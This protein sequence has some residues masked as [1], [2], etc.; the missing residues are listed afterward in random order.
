ME[1]TVKMPQPEKPQLRTGEDGFTLVETVIAMVIMMVVALGA[2]SV[3]AY[4]TYN[5]T[6]GS[7]RAQVLSIAQES[8]ENLRKYKFDSTG[9]DASLAGTSN[10]TQTVT[11]GS[12]NYTLKVVIDDDPFTA[13][14]QTIPS[15]NFK[16]FQV[17]VTP[18]GGGLPWAQTA[19]SVYTLRSRAE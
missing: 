1:R 8:L 15:T 5:N 3:F 10:Y 2:A 9:T 16:S 18:Q 12:R 19:V 13:G 11:R 17:T 14:V 7:E 4:A 6:G